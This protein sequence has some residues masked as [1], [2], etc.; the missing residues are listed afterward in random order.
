MEAPISSAHGH[1]PVND[2]SV[3]EFHGWQRR[4]TLASVNEAIRLLQSEK[5]QKL[6]NQHVHCIAEYRAIEI[7]DESFFDK[8]FSTGKEVAACLAFAM[9]IGWHAVLQDLARLRSTLLGPPLARS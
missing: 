9:E 5:F 3:A 8:A 7:D 6:T 1:W 2:S 4:L